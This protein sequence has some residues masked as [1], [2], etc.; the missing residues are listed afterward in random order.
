MWQLPLEMMT[1]ELVICLRPLNAAVLVTSKQQYSGLTN[2]IWI[3]LQA[4][5]AITDGA[6]N[7]DNS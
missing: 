4:T 7:D 6:F 2:Q 3:H 5:T 1:A